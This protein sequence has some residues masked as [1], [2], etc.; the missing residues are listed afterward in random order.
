VADLD[1]SLARASKLLGL[2]ALALALAIGAP[3]VVLSLARLPSKPVRL[4]LVALLLVENLVAAL[5]GRYASCW[6]DTS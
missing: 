6:Q 2:Y 3:L 1:M 5:S 4:G